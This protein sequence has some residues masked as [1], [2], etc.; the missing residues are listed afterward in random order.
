[1]RELPEE[2]ASREP[3]KVD[4][5]KRKGLFDYV[6]AVLPSL[7]EAGASLYLY[8]ASNEPKTRQVLFKYT[9]SAL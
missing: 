3:F 2:I 8:Y 6:E 9:P 5:S 1:V 4:C 7:L